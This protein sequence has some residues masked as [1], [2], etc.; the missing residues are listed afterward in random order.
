M[1]ITDIST[2]EHKPVRITIRHENGLFRV[3]YMDEVVGETTSALVLCE[4]GYDPVYYFDRS[5]V[6]AARLVENRN[7]TRCPYKGT[8]SYFEVHLAGKTVHNG[9]W[10][11]LTPIDA[12][13]GIAQK[14]AFDGSIFDIIKITAVTLRTP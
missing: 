12:V 14:I 9:A 5:F 1:T 13:K 10:T 11:Y 6:K 7:T 4:M 3:M 2:N 8:A